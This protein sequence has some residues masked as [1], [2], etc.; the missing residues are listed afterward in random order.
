MT[1]PVNLEPRRK[2]VCSVT[3]HVTRFV[4]AR[5]PCLDLPRHTRLGP[6]D[7]AREWIFVKIKS[8]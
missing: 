6:S 5:T 7:L 3:C 8:C 4:T 2:P 1:I